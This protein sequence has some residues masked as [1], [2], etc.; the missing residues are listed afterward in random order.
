MSFLS[1]LVRMLVVA[2]VTVGVTAI[3]P[4]WWCG[5]DADAFL[6]R[7]SPEQVALAREVARWVTTE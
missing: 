4:R 3:V 1:R 6:A 7:T 2:A 5:R